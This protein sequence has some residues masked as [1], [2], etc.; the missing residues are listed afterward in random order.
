MSPLEAKIACMALLGFVSF[1]L[2]AIPWKLYK[3]LATESRGR[4]LTVSIMLCFGAGVLL[5]TAM[6]HIIPEVSV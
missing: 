1:I 2:G 3:Y 5:A 6:I 4:K